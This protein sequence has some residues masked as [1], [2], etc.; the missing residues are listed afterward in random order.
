MMQGMSTSSQTP[1]TNVDSARQERL[2]LARLDGDMLAEYQISRLNKMLAEVLPQNE[3]YKQKLG[4]V[5]TSIHSLDELASLPF[6]FKDELV[7]NDEHRDMVANLT[8]PLDH[9]VRYHRTSGT[10]GRPLVVLDTIDDWR[11]WVETWQYVLD[12]ADIK[13]GDRC[14]MAFS[15]GP[16]I[17]FWSAFDAVM[18]RGGLTVPTGGM[19]T[20]ARVEL[21]R[22]LRATAIFCTP[23]YA[24]HMA[25]VALENPM[26]GPKLNAMTQR[27]PALI[28]AAS[29][30]YCHV[31]TH[32]RQSST[33][34]NTTSGRPRVPD[35]R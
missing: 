10:R 11:W 25:E 22:S 17:G 28:S 31:S 30:T 5:D 16:F 13:A 27:S 12:A 4:K 1:K 3:F 21:I 8:Y 34:S 35:V 32:H 19:N 14:V 23:S 29:S 2:R 24:L 20:L 6:T 9:Y 15:F 7:A 18:A 33:V 26:N